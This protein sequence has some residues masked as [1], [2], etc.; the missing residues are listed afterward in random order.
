MSILQ[1]T[2]YASV[3]RELFRTPMWAE[4]RKALRWYYLNDVLCRRHG[5]RIR[6]DEESVHDAFAWGDS[7]EGR[8][9]WHQVYL[10]WSRRKE[11]RHAGVQQPDLAT[12][13][14]P[15]NTTFVTERN[16]VAFTELARRREEIRIAA[17]EARARRQQEERERRERAQADYWKQFKAVYD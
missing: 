1:T 10:A 17:L 6:W 7:L 11:L 2:L 5:F 3:K 8:D 9:F 13:V 16:A 4:V 14:F 15:H 12:F